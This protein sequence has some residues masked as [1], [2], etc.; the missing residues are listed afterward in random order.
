MSYCLGA[1]DINSP[2][3]RRLASRLNELMPVKLR[4][5]SRAEVSA[6]FDGLELVEPGVVRAPE[7]R[8][9]SDADRANPATVWGGLARKN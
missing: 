8:P 7:W 9:D 1:Y 4:F 2:G 5:R 3:V 6:L